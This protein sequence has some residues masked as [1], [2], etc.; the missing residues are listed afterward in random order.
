MFDWTSII[1]AIYETDYYDMYAREGLWSC[2]TARRL[3]GM[4]FESQTNATLPL[5]TMASELERRVVAA[6]LST[7]YQI[8]SPKWAEEGV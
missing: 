8:L 4:V 6:A 2:V 1:T 5:S 7:I 3:R